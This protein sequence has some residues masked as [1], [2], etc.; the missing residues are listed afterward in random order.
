V[1]FNGLNYGKI[2]F[3]TRNLNFSLPIFE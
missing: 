2:D 1:T 3:V